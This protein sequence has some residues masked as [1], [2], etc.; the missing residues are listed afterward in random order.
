VQHNVA[1]LQ[2]RDAEA[3]ALRLGEPEHDVEPTRTTE[4]STSSAQ[5]Q[6]VPQRERQPTLEPPAAEQSTAPQEPPTPSPWAPADQP[7][8]PQ[9]WTPAVGRRGAG[10]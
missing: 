6:S 2:A 10:R 1:L 8:E 3:A 9:Q 7:V 4:Q 5:P